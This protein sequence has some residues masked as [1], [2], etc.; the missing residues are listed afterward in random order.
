MRLALKLFAPLLTLC[1]LSLSTAIEAASHREAPLISNDPSADI[2]DVYAFR[3]WTN[4]NNVVFILNVIPAQEPSAGPNYFNFAD[5]VLYAINVD[6]N[7]D[8]KAEDIVYEVQFKTE[9][10]GA[11]AGLK[12]PLS[13]VAIPQIT[14]LDGAGSDGLILRQRYSI[15]EVRGKNRRNLGSDSMFAVPSNVGP[16]T[17]PGYESLAAQGIYSLGNG[18]RVFAGQ[19]DETFNIDLGAVFDTVNLRRSP[20]PLLNDA[21]DATDSTNPFG[22]DALSGFNV[23]TIAIEVPIAAITDNPNAVIGVYASTSR[24]EFREM[25]D[26]GIAKSSGRWM[27]VSRMAN[28]LV[29]ELIIGT[30]Q[31]DLWNTT[32]PHKEQRFLDFYLNSRLATALNIRYGLPANNLGIPETGRT[33]LV[34]ALLKYPTQPQNGAC[35][36]ASPCSE[37]LRL[38]LAVAPTPPYQQKRLSVLA[39]DNAGWPNGR[40]PSD[41][42]TD[43]ALRVVAGRLISPTPPS[44]TLLLGDG[45]NYNIG[46]PG[47]N[48]TANGIYNV[49]PYLP[50]PHDGRNRRHIDCNEALANAC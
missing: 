15:T 47:S 44:G 26:D 39:A 35:S 38:N 22:N 49:F 9:I 16:L 12:L 43:I 36:T 7:G 21:E 2:T 41:D 50:T 48:V 27:Q 8:G 14:T 13:Y 17:M 11:L 1:S 18:G 25:D 3:S 34:N 31:K 45:V 6:V 42:V 28:P 32:E 40:R 46:A 4:P 19:R 10:R 29:N 30:A 37:L 24:Q 5:D 23:S 20:F 33:D